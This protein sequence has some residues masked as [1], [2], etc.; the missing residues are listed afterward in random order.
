MK[1][2]QLK[3]LL[4]SHIIDRVTGKLLGDGNISI[5]QKRKPRF[6]FSHCVQDGKW[7]EHCYD[8][9][10]KHIEL[11]PSKPRKI[12]DSRIKKGYTE[13]VYVQSLTSPAIDILKEM[14]YTDRKKSIPFDLLQEHFSPVTLAWW[15]QDDGHLKV[16]NNKVNK[17]IFSRDSF[18]KSENKRLIELLDYFY[19]IQFKPDG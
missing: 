5:E 7:A 18:S 6:R 14:W 3:E 8:E 12:I 4:P 1:S 2:A 10:K 9:L 16:Q 19:K 11:T 15:Y 13:S 17:I